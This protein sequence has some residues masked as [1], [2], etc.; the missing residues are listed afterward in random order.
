MYAFMGTRQKVNTK[1]NKYEEI[2]QAKR[3]VVKLSCRLNTFL[4]FN[5]DEISL[6]FS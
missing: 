6:E 2:I 5:P 4:F 1:S 3:L